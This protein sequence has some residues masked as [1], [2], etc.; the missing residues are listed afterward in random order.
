V[1]G[2][3]PD[4]TWPETA[5]GGAKA[6]V[7][8]QREH[9]LPLDRAPLPSLAAAAH[10]PQRGLPEMPVAYTQTGLA[11]D[12]AWSWSARPEGVTGCWLLPPLAA[13]KSWGQ[14]ASAWPPSGGSG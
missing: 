14:A 4:P 2:R 6:S 13:T 8:V 11:L 7:S 3:P 12:Q 9:A 10:D 5:K 1:D